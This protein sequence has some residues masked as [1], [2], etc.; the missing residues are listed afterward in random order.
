MTR[1]G[2]LLCGGSGT[3]LHPLTRAVPKSL[4]PV[5]NKPMVY[6]PLS[7][8]MLAGLRSILVITTPHDAPAFQR[9]LGDGTQWGISLSYATQPEPAGIAQ[10]WL[11]AADWLDN[12]PSC[13]ALGDNLLYGAGLREVLMTASARARGATCFGYHV[14]DPRS[15]GVATV[16]PATG[17]V[18]SIEEKPATPRSNWAIPGLYFVDQLAVPIAAALT[19][20]PRGELEVT[21]LLRAYASAGPLHLERLSRGYAWL[22]AGTHDTLLDAGNFIATIERRCGLT[23]GD[24]LAIAQ[25]NGWLDTP[26]AS[27]SG[28]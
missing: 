21:D 7:T 20:S 11:I 3:R 27:A 24:P 6:Y 1:R 8:L 5:A 12:A 19:P 25:S 14:A 15:Y 22:D 16:D 28:H 23:V 2:I 10:A 4:L 9:L 18:T 13:L 26:P 17:L